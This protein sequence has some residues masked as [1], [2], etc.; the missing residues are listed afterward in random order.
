M[1][2]TCGTSVPTRPSFVGRLKSPDD[3]TT[4]QQ[5]FDRYWKL[6]YEV[7]LRSGLTESEAKDVVQETVVTVAKKIGSFEYNPAQGSF[8]GWLLTI[9]RCRIV[10]EFRKRPRFQTTSIH[11]PAAD[12]A[13]TSTID[14]IP[15][16]R[17]NDLVALW[18][19]EWR[20][21]LMDVAVERVKRQV[22]ARHFQVFELSVLR[23][24]SA[25]QIARALN[26]NLGQVYLTKHRLVKLV[27]NE[28][29][30]I[31]NKVV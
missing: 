9:T 18:D 11:D 24:W 19:E 27:K 28:V 17:T 26:L 3:N 14:R 22:K 21:N 4:W 2:N 13:L 8:K 30:S 1:R 20:K 5:F 15:D 16:E 7:A 29:K 23:N 25:H 10:D 31:E 6:I 12:S